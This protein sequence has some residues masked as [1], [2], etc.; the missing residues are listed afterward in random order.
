MWWHLH[1][2]L[3]FAISESGIGKRAINALVRR[4]LKPVSPSTDHNK[5]SLTLIAFFGQV[6]EQQKQDWHFA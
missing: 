6:S 5:G 2:G 4:G 1:R 3:R